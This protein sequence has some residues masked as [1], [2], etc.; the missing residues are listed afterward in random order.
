M[1]NPNDFS[2]LVMAVLGAK[3]DGYAQAPSFYRIFSRGLIRCGRH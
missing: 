2:V 3:F 1:A